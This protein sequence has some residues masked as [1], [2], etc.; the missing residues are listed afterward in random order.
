MY[1][2]TYTNKSNTLTNPVV[3]MFWSAKR[4]DSTTCQTAITNF[5]FPQKQMVKDFSSTF[6]SL[7]ESIYYSDPSDP[8]K[9]A[10]QPYLGQATLNYTF[11]GSITP[12]MTNKVLAIISAQPLIVGGMYQ[13]Q[14]MKFLSRSVVLSPADFSFTFNYMHPGNY[15][16][17]FLY[18]TNGD[19]AP[20]S[21]DW[22]SINGANSFSLSALGTQNVTGQINFQIP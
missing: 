21:G 22:I 2:K 14:N 7:A 12:V 19:L 20:T 9:E 5:S 11:S 16:Y 18:D 8:Y 4:A 15:Y 10:S 1:F 17:Y 3:H 6:N 13:P